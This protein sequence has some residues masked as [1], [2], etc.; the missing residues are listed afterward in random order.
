MPTIELK[1][2]QLSELLGKTVSYDTLQY[3]LQWISLDIDEY[4]PEEGIIKV[5]FNPNRPDFSSPEGVVRLL[6]GYYGLAAGLQPYVVKE[7]KEYF[8]VSTKVRKVRPY[9]VSAL[10]RFK[11]ALN[12]EQVI[13][14]MRMQEILH[15]AVGRDRKKVAIGIHDYESV[16]GPYLY[17]TV[18]PDGIKF[19]PLHLEAYELTPQEI[20]EEHPMGIQYAHLLEG[21]EEYPIIYDAEGKVVS[22][23]PIIN[24]TYT[25]V[26]PDKTKILLLD[27]TGT[28]ERAV[29]VSLNI[30][31]STF[32]DMG[33]EL[34]SV[35]VIYEDEPEKAKFTPDLSPNLWKARIDYINSYI[36]LNLSGKEMIECLRKMRLDAKILDKNTLEIQVPAYRDDIMH[37]VDL[38]EEV[39]MGFG[40]QN[41]TL[42]VNMEGFGKYHPILQA[43]QKVREIM[44]GVGCLEMVNNILNSSNDNKKFL[45]KLKKSETIV[46]ANPVSSE[47]D[48]VRQSILASLMKNVQFNRSEEKPF[49]LFEVGDVVLFDKSKLTMSRR[50]L[51]LGCVAHSD[52]SDYSEIKGILDHFLRT[53]GIN[54]EVN[55]KPVENPSFIPGR[56]ADIIYEGHKIGTVGEI[57]PQ[58]ILNFGLDYPTAGFE[59]NLMPFIEI[60]E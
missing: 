17:T 25:T 52:T 34:E 33:G 7:G 22:L 39:A 53:F 57:H 42:T 56:A 24:G 45:L 50:E 54:Q 13:T 10:V 6:K 58:V 37:E 49:H 31:A 11:K 36:G 35:K 48:T 21:F 5:E 59:L 55:F 60:E 8:K 3:D 16:K 32:A 14:L 2:D 26:T 44:V 12:E 51:H 1:I 47:F 9:V 40:Y 27:L 43:A 28:D 38:V 4:D 30:L 46:I 18:A 19:R 29:N 41:L 15:W 20:L 23:P